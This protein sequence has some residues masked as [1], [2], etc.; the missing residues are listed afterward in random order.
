[1]WQEELQTEGSGANQAD[2]HWVIVA[3][4]IFIGK[5]LHDL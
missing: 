2:R 5:L 4:F 3:K 1:V